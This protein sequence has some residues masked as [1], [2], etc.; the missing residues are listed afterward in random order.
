[1]SPLTLRDV[2]LG[3][4][5]DLVREVVGGIVALFALAVMPVL[6]AILCVFLFA[7]ALVDWWTR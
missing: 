2:A 4:T 6:L 1:M 7:V 3:W 5:S